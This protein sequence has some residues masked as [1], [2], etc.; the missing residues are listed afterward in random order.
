MARIQI[1]YLVQVNL[2]LLGVIVTSFLLSGKVFTPLNSQLLL[3]I[4][5]LQI[6]AGSRKLQILMGFLVLCSFTLDSLRGFKQFLV[7][8]LSCLSVLNKLVRLDLDFRLEIV[9][10]DQ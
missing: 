2:L 6:R 4:L 7:E 8:L 3:H 10:A 5:T 1:F 9:E